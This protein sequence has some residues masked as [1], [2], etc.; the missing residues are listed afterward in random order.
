MND[1]TELIFIDKWSESTF[2]IPNIKYYY[3]VAGWSTQA[4]YQDAQAFDNKTEIYLTC[5]DFPN[6]KIEKSNIDQMNKLKERIIQKR[7]LKFTI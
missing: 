1:N 4:K 6:L 7:D 5:I 3:K 2:N